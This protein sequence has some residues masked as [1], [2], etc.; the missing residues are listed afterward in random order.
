MLRHRLAI[1]IGLSF[2]S[3]GTIS[4]VDVDRAAADSRS[5][6]V[7]EQLEAARQ[8]ARRFGIHAAPTFLLGKTGEVPTVFKPERLTPEVFARALD[9]LLPSG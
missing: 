6:A 8:E 4:L 2:G 1:K 9:A 7:T 5:N 3:A